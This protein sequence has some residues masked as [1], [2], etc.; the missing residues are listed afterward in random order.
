ME[1]FMNELSLQE[2][3]NNIQEFTESV[4]VFTKIVS[5]LN[6]V[7]CDKTLFKKGDFYWHKKAIS[8]QDFR[9]SLNKIKDK[10]ILVSFK[11]IVFD[12]NNPKNWLDEQVHSNQDNF[13]SV[14]LD[15]NVTG[16]TLAEVAER[17]IQNSQN[18]YL[19]LNFKNSSFSG[20]TETK[21]TKNDEVTKK[22]DC[23]D[24]LEEVNIWIENNCV[25]KPIVE[26]TNKFERTS[27][28][29]KGATVYKEKETD[30]Y[31]YLDTLH[32]NHYE[33]FNSQKEHLG[34]ADLEGNLDIGKKDSSKNGKIEI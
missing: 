11:K 20:E 34:E 14:T 28:T 31:W 2:Q 5:K 15:C 26:N 19:L 16:Q 33:V 8:N 1:M 24:S 22:I 3:Y 30:Y 13:I 6:E 7:K 23:V 9:S 32:N 25:I 17:K 10:I 12:R 21:I 27:K 4:I 29:V 18:T